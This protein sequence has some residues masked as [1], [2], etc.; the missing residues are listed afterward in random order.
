PMELYMGMLGHAVVRRE[1]GAVFAHIHPAGT[2]SMAAQEFFSGTRALPGKEGADQG[3]L[4]PAHS[5]EP[6]SAEQLT[7]PYGFPQ[8]GTYRLWVQTKSQGR[9]M[10]GAFVV[11][12]VAAH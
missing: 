2:V 4:H 6:G 1:D 7:F 9:I 5:S 8:P 12:V 3:Q 10:T 11:K